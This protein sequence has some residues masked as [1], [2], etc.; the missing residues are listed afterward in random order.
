MRC[1]H[2]AMLLSHSNSMLRGFMR[3]SIIARFVSFAIVGL[4][5]AGC[6]TSPSERA[7]N[8][9]LS[10][11]KEAHAEFYRD[12]LQKPAYV[13]V[14]CG[15]VIPPITAT[16]GSWIIYEFED[17]DEWV[18]N[19]DLNPMVGG[20]DRLGDLQ[21]NESFSFDISVLLDSSKA[22]LPYEYWNGTLTLEQCRKDDN[23]TFEMFGWQ[24]T[25]RGVYQITPRRAWNAKRDL[26]LSI[27]IGEVHNSVAGNKPITLTPVLFWYP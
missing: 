18:S 21:A 27:K 25:N 11:A 15:D 5:M 14:K 13:T 8:A 16:S 6:A 4:A 12:R 2:A 19:L 10:G 17:C 3:S 9:Y 22:S 26:T 20:T 23:R 1:K 24:D 7:A